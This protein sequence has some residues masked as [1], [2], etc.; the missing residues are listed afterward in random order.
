VLLDALGTLVELEPPWPLLRAILA[1]RHG[2]DVSEREAQEA[3]LVE[4]SFYRD[5][6]LEGAGAESLA[7]LRGRCALVLREQLPATAGLS[8]RELTEALLDSLRFV[9]HE[10]A[11][12][13]LAALR[14][15][16]LRLGVVSNWDCS[17]GNVL[18]QL[19][20][21]GA[22][23]AVVVS[24]EVGAPKPDPAIFRAALAALRCEAED[25]LFVGDS[26]E[27]DVEGARAAGIRA[28]LL[29]RRGGGGTGPGAER[30]FSLHELV[31][32]AVTAA[33]GDRSP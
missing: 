25:A 8:E 16:G 18:S 22:I 28:L 21:G 12:P 20:L 2:I 33:A 9:P 6:H 24:A 13:A 31:D 29:D 5:H 15:A 14:Q 4:M 27:T 11:A 3:L 10:D 17:L 26:L 19:G 32:L 7:A 23:D 30:I 1:A